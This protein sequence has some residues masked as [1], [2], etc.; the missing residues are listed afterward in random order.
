[1]SVVSVLFVCMGN[2][3]RSPTGEGVFSQYIQD[4]GR[5]EQFEIDSAGTIAY[6]S[7]QPADQR[8]REAAH[9]RGYRL[10]SIARPVTA[11]D[12]EYFD[13]VVAMDRDNFS[14]LV[15]L[16]AGDN[17]NVKMLGEF[18]P[19]IKASAEPLDVPDPYYGGADGFE[20]VIDMCERA[21]PAIFDHCVELRAKRQ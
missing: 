15:A 3:C 20:V 8:M 12:L 9:R 21:C 7:G 18:L 17:A 14:D 19:S 10:D 11:A 2:I 16:R 5:D 1:M 6:H 13:L 4:R